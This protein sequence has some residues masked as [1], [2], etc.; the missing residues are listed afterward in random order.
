MLL[1]VGENAPAFS[2]PDADMETIDLAD[3]L[4]KK[5]IVLFL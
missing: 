4:G 2:L 1:K 5:R 3:C